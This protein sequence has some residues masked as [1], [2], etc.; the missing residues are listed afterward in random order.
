[1]PMGGLALM[2]ASMIAKKKAADKIESRQNDLLSLE[3]D[4]QKKYQNNITAKLDEALKTFDPESQTNNLADTIDKNENYLADSLPAATTDTDYN[5]GSDAPKVVQSDLAK[6]LAASLSK[7]REYAKTSAQ[8]SGYNNNMMNNNLA[9]SNAG[10]GI[11]RNINFS[12]GS[13]NVLGAEL[14]GA[15]GAGDKYKTIADG[16]QFASIMYGMGSGGTAG[17]VP[18]INPNASYATT[19]ARI[20]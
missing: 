8:N 3:G 6:N 14:V 4:R 12:R 5:T 2:G 11:S 19:P 16:L 9:I 1:M 17:N 10:T 15:Q 20:G 7:G 18:K 13:N